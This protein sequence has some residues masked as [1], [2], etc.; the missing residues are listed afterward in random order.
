MPFTVYT[1]RAA[2]GV[3]VVEARRDPERPGRDCDVECRCA[4]A[5]ATLDVVDRLAARAGRSGALVRLM[6][7]DLLVMRGRREREKAAMPQPPRAAKE[8]SKLHV[9]PYQGD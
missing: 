4:D 1:R 3:L 2:S 8:R 6:D 5:E 7:Q 9:D